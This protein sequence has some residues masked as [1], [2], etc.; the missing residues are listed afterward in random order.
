MKSC[1]GV[2]IVKEIESILSRIRFQKV[3]LIIS[4][5]FNIFSTVFNDIILNVNKV[6]LA[7]KI[8]ITGFGCKRVVLTMRYLLEP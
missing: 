1:L 7:M 6:F 8:Y 5:P 4:F 2:R 3:L